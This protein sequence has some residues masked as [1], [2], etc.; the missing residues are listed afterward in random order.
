MN[1]FEN[2]EALDNESEVQYKKLSTISKIEDMINKQE[3]IYDENNE[4]KKRERM[5]YEIKEHEIMNR[6]ISNKLI[7]IDDQYSGTLYLTFI[8][9]NVDE[10]F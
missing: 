4:I 1:K 6:Y 10:L 5:N 3:G 7:L 2:Y 8:S 9:G